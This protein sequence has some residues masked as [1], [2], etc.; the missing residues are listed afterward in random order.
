MW[1]EFRYEGNAFSVHHPDKESLINH[2]LKHPINGY[3]E[4]GWDLYLN[5]DGSVSDI[6]VG[7]SE[8][9]KFSKSYLETLKKI[10]EGDYHD[11]RN[12]SYTF[13]D[14]G[15]EKDFI[16]ILNDNGFT[17]IIRKIRNSYIFKTGYGFNEMDTK[18]LGSGYFQFKKLFS[19]STYRRNAA[20][21]EW[22]GKFEDSR[23]IYKNLKKELPNNW[24]ISL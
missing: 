15:K 7:S 4:E 8:F 21:A 22:N 10:I 9:D 12:A 11:P 3:I 19:D 5:I 18:Y 23:T 6:K 1:C 14:K 13:I 16:V 2:T 17:V 24:E 20:I